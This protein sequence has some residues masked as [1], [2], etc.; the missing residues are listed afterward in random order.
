MERKYAFGKIEI[1]EDF[2]VT[3]LDPLELKDGSFLLNLSIHKVKKEVKPLMNLKVN[4]VKEK[5]KRNRPGGSSP[6]RR[7]ENFSLDNNLISWKSNFNEFCGDLLNERETFEKEHPEL[8][9]A[10][11]LIV[12]KG[13][14]MSKR[15]ATDGL[16]VPSKE[17]YEGWTTESGIHDAIKNLRKRRKAFIANGGKVVGYNIPTS[18]ANMVCIA[19]QKKVEKS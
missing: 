13:Q 18:K 14:M 15:R 9:F 10:V 3:G 11:Y 2:E 17:V 8:E 4:E 6:D 12:V 7:K 19:Y 5:C 16:L 1:N